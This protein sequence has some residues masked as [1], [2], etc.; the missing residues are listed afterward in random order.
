M[1][2]RM[3]RELAKLRRAELPPDLWDRA[4]DGPRLEPLGRPAR[5]RLVAAAA[6]FAMFAAGGILVWNAF[7][8]AGPEQNALAGPA[9]IAVPPRGDVA[10]VFLTD[11]RPVWVVHHEEGGLSV[12]DGFSSHRPFGFEELL[13]WC[14][15]DRTFVEPA[16]GAR[17]DESGTYV[18]SGP[19]PTGAATFAFEVLARGSDGEPTSIRVG[20]MLRERPRDGVETVHT[21]GPGCYSGVEEDHY[22]GLQAHRI[23][24]EA[25]WNS[26]TALA[27]AGPTGWAAVRG[28]FLVE[29]DGLARLCARVIAGDCEQGAIIRGIDGPGFVGRVVLIPQG[30]DPYAAA[31]VWLGKV[32]DG[33]LDDLTLPVPLQTTQS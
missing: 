14:P 8:P 31:P 2:D 20:P 13:G 29:P 16:H 33:L 5:T 9:V 10:P 24:A 7:R 27:A 30:R 12:I 19:A 6:A 21:T 17:F 11:G 4:L 26:P 23:P 22:P 1:T 15:S 28:Y 32:R 18:G 25:V 3:H